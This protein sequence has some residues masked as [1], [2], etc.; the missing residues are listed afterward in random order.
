[1]MMLYPFP[2]VIMLNG[3]IYVTID[4]LFNGSDNFL[5]IY[6]LFCG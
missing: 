1:M 4:V 3:I 2:E 5:H 6:M